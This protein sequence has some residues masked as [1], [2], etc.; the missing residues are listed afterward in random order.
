MSQRKGRPTPDLPLFDFPL[1]GPEDGPPAPLP[2]PEAPDVETAA[3]DPPAPVSSPAPN[4]TDVAELPLTPLPVPKPAAARPVEAKPPAP[5][6]TQPSLFDPIPETAEPVDEAGAA[7][8]DGPEAQQYVAAHDDALPAPFRARILAGLADF[9]I[10]LAMVGAMVGGA[11]VLGVTV[12]LRD[13]PALGLLVMAFSFLYWVVP[14]AFWGQTPG[15]AWIGIGSRA[16]DNEPLSF[17]QTALR[18]LGALLTV[19][20]AGVPLAL[21]ATG[22]SLSDRLSQSKTHQV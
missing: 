9:A 4:R 7:A 8:P 3:P 21:A 16:L 15:M 13:W 17:S 5:L 18:W 2:R 14:L 19:L 10:H 6:G 22:S 11:T 12:G 1:D 20:L